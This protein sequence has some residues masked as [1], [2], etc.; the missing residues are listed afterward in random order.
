MRTCY[1]CKQEKELTDFYNSCA[2]CKKCDLEYRDAWRKK[3][4]EKCV[5]RHKILWKRKKSRPCKKC[6]EGFVGK[7]LVREYCCTKCKLLGEVTKRKNGCWEWKGNLHNNGYG[8]TTMYETNKREHVH[9]ISYR[10][11][12]GEIPEGLCVCHQCDNRKCINPEHLWLG[13]HKDNNQDCIKKGRQ[14]VGDKKNPRRG[15]K[16]PH[17]KLTDEKVKEIRKLIKSGKR[18]TVIAREYGVCSSVIYGV[19]DR[20]GWK[21]IPEDDS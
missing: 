9:R 5:E 20:K 1:R 7:G 19:R 11:F 16:N 10:V 21:H 8:Y 2:Y 15:E 4:K 14:A 13:T 18:C 17:A 3:N 6:G 12:K